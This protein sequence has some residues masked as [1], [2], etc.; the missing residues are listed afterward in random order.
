M[1]NL[2][3]VFDQ[4][5]LISAVISSNATGYLLSSMIFRRKIPTTNSPISS[6]VL[7]SSLFSAYIRV[8]TAKCALAVAPLL[9]IF[10]YAH[11]EVRVYLGS[12]PLT[13]YYELWLFSSV[14]LT[15]EGQSPTQA[16]FSVQSHMVV[17][18][19]SWP[20]ASHKG[21]CIEHIACYKWS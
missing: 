18:H 2:V 13:S 1:L 11:T 8:D 16:P 10:R 17:W 4:G 14:Y 20:R 7:C 9:R 12:S 21:F 15:F 3:I 5:L 6:I 19:E